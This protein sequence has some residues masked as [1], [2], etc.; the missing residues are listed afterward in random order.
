[1]LNRM[2]TQAGTIAIGGHVKPDGDCIGSSMGLYQHI[3]D[4]YKK[5]QV[6]V[7]LEE[8]LAAYECL[9]GIGEIRHEITGEEHYDLFISLDCADKSRL[10]FSLPLFESAD[11]TLCIDH[12][13]S[14]GGYAEENY[15]VPDSSST[16]ELVYELADKEKLGKAASEALYVGIVHDTGA[17]QYSAAKPS[18]FR[19]AAEL[20]EKGIDGPRLI[21]DTYY[22]KT[23]TQNQILGRALM[24]SI[25]FLNGRCIVSY[26]KKDTMEFY[27]VTPKEMDGIVSHLRNTKGVKVAVLMYE[28]EP[29]VY[30]V[31]LRSDD[32]VDVSTIACQ[33]G[34]GGHKKAAGVTM[35]GSF[36]NIINRLS[37]QIDKQLRDDE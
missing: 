22:V 26:F 37:A 32:S 34:G 18:T 36:Y 28:L 16:S 7:Y 25:L 20:L 19:M 17:F 13:V 14:N 3:S 27:G 11:H 33:Y 30:K 8:T 31:S 6:H 4:N 9:E 24:E 21:A 2:L 29:G 15:V 35:Q 1:M 5:E 12:H 10:G 23:F